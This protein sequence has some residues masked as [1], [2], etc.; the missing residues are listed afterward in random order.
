MEQEFEEQAYGAACMIMG[1]AVWQLITEGQT[2]TQEA[3]AG[4]VVELRERQPDIA[5]SI[6]LS[7]VRQA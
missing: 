4:M 5:S 7:V 1:E 2:V 6:A 3:I